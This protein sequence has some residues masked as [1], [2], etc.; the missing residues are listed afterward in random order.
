MYMAYFQ[1]VEE[2]KYGMN[3]AL[4][5]LLAFCQVI[6]FDLCVSALMWKKWKWFC[7]A[8]TCFPHQRPLEVQEVLC[9]LFSMR[10]LVDHTQ[11]KT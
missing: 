6:T 10:V 4:C 1:L 3:C 7:F 11:I 9:S 2:A 5:L 8:K